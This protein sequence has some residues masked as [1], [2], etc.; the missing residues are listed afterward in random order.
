MCAHAGPHPLSYSAQRAM[1][2]VL[3]VRTLSC[4]GSVGRA[5]AFGKDSRLNGNSRTTGERR[6][7]WARCDD[8]HATPARHEHPCGRG[9]EVN[10]L[11]WIE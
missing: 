5:A 4:R 11:R 7:K 6:P 2:G 3:M 10:D 1:G 8:L 9:D